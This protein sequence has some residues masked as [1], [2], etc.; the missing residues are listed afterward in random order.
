MQVEFRRGAKRTALRFFGRYLLL[1]LIALYLLQAAHAQEAPPMS[2]SVVL[3]LKLVSKTHVKPVTG[4]VVSDE[5]MVLVPADFV[6]ADSGPAEAEILVLD[7]GT[8]IIGHGRPAKII[9]RSLPGG[10]A[11]LSVNGLK[12]P[13]ITLAESTLGD[14]GELHLAAFPPAE[15]IAKGAQPLWVAVE[16]LADEMNR[17][18]ILSP[19]TPLPYITGPIID[20]CGYLS[21]LS[22][23][24]GAQSLDSGKAPLTFFADELSRILDS[25][26]IKLPRAS[27]R[28]QVQNTSASALEIND[29]AENTV[30]ETSD[31]EVLATETQQADIR[32]ASSDA[33]QV[34]VVDPGTLMPPIAADRP[35]LWRSVPWWLLPIGII[36]LAVLLWKG[37]FFFRAT[38]KKSKQISSPRGAN[39]RQSASEEPDTTQLQSGADAAVGKPR[40]VPV[41]EFNI[42]DMDKLPAGCNGLVLVEGVVGADIPFKRYCAV[43]TLQIDIV[44]GR[45]AADLC[46]E[47]PAISRAHVRLE[48]DGNSM[49][50]SDLG[51]SNG[52]FIKG[53]P[54]LPGEVF[55]VDAEDEIF[56][57]GVRFRISVITKKADL[58]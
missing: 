17:R 56:L 42:P 41:E 30:Q 10:L 19:A 18:V 53:I 32:T 43:N 25:M 2:P 15:Y 55:F 6:T 23:A 16:V 21:G 40:S 11:L 7:G 8:D 50:L 44:I 58:V 36:I 49:T 22:L 4:I 3:V 20:A 28:P 29:V 47:H 31:T 48:C 45:G 26:Q 33:N 12:R 34:A 51:S 38:N 57:G 54:C 37:F 46:I 14:K 52:T 13:G 35:S 5:G 39:H 24:S 1:S 27:C 9:N